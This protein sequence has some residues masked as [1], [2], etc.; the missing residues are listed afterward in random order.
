MEEMIRIRKEEESDYERVEKITRQ[1]FWNLYVLGC[2]EHY[3]VHVMRSHQDFFPE[4]D[5]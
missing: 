1:A 3:L 4:L 2:V 5:L